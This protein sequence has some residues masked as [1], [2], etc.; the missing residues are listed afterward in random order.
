MKSRVINKTV[1][2]QY[3]CLMRAKATN[4]I[5]MFYAHGNGIVVSEGNNVKKSRLG[6]HSNAWY[7][8]NFEMFDGEVT[9]QN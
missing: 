2:Y 1:V 3:P 6:H 8:E 4:D 7:M 9:L 5:V